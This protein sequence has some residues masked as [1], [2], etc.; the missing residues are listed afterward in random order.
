MEKYIKINSIDQCN[1][2]IGQDTLHPLVSVAEIP[3]MKLTADHVSVTCDFYTVIFKKRNSS[4]MFEKP[5]Q[6]IG[7]DRS[8]LTV[9]SDIWIVTFHPDLLCETSLEKEMKHYTFFS[10][11]GITT[12][13]LSAQQQEI[14]DECL[15]ALRKELT[16][17]VDR[18][19]RKVIV[20][21]LELMLNYCLRFYDRLYSFFDDYDFSGK[22]VI[23]FCTHGGSRFSK[24]LQT[25]AGMEKDAEIVKGLSVPRDN[26]GQSKA[27][28]L[29]WLKGIGMTE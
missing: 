2:M 8:E 9:G 12:L 20:S 22:T 21:H 14:I 16:H 3:E 28:V 1:K 15:Y 23:P 24:A 10:R 6:A 13:P 5:G 4:L 17:P 27:D 29:K 19:S 7:I 18:H 25:I 26:V 11:K